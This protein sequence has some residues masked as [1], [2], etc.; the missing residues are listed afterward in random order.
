MASKFFLYWGSGSPPCWRAML[1]A[2][3]KKVPGIESKLL[4]FSKKENKGEDVLKWNHRG[5]LPTVV[6]DD[7]YAINESHAIC[8]FLDRL[9]AKQGTKLTPDDPKELAKVLQRKY[10]FL[11]LNKKGM[12]Y[13][14]YKAFN[15]ADAIDADVAAKRLADFMNE[16][17]I[18]DKY[19]AEGDYIAGNNLSIADLVL[20]PDLAISV[21]YGLDL[22][23]IAPNLHKYYERMTKLPSVQKTWPPHWKDSAVPKSLF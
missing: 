15:A 5:E 7:S 19:A 11:N 12:D 6:V 10:E 22:G 1:V 3:E 13:I 4:E 18:W 20:F 14:Q 17:K 23:K 8:E 9:Y 21:R 2:E 16:V